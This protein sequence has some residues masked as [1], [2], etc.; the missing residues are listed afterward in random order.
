MSTEELSLELDDSRISLS[1]FPSPPQ[2][3]CLFLKRFS[4]FNITHTIPSAVRLVGL[5][6]VVGSLYSL[7]VVQQ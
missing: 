6:C 2:E 3:Q 1:K 7:F 4:V 5:L